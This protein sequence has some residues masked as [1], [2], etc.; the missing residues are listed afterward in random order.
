MV[1]ATRQS[2]G[3]APLQAF[4]VHGGEEEAAAAMTSLDKL[5]VD[6]SYVSVELLDPSWQRVLRSTHN[7]IEKQVNFDS[8]LAVFTQSDSSATIGKFFS[9]KGITYYPILAPVTVQSRVGGFLLRWRKLTNSRESVERLSQLLGAKATIIVGNADGTFW[10]DMV[11]P[12]PN[13]IPS[14][15]RAEGEVLQY[16]IGQNQFLASLKPITGTPWVVL[17]ELSVDDVLQPARS[18]LR[19]TLFVGGGLLLLG[20]VLAWLVSRNITRPLNRLT[21]AATEIANGNH[22]AAVYVDRTDEIGKL[23]RAFNAMMNQVGRAR[24]DLEYKIVQTAEMNEELRNLSAYLQNVREQERIHIAREMHDELGQLLT[25]FKMDV[26]WLNK[27]LADT[28]DPAVREK[29]EEMVKIVDESVKFVRRL[30]AELRPSI[31]DDLGLVPALEWHSQEFERRYNIKIDFQSEIQEL[32]TTSLIATGLFRMYQESLTNVARHSGASCV[33]TRLKLIA[34]TLYL[35][36]ADDGHGFDVAK[37]ERKTLGLL[38]M[39][40]RA[41]MIGGRLDIQSAQGEGTTIVIAVPMPVM[42][43]ERMQ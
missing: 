5:R 1:V 22:A 8:L 14:D 3:Q 32:S 18:F 40:E 12:V 17:V 23:S 25:G 19:S 4:L 13:P 15:A 20:I 24:K 31:L 9:V 35:T 38:G 21:G 42:A 6:T 29:L 37:A 43:T 34:G 16:S 33:E 10:T 30:A 36:I 28:N 26:S 27:R 39:R 7:S 41:I 2:A 11:N